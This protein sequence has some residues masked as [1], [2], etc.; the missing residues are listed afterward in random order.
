MYIKIQNRMEVLK[1]QEVIKRYIQ[2]QETI[3]EINKQHGCCNIMRL[4]KNTAT[5]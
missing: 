3:M 4:V 2:I 1:V 5:E